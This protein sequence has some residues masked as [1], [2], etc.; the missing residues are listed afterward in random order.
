MKKSPLISAALIGALA[1]ILA[2]AASALPPVKG[3]ELKT[4][5]WRFAFR[6]P[7][8]TDDVPVVLVTIDDQS[9]E[10]LP[11][12][13]PWPRDYYA[14]VVRNLKKAGARVVALDLIFDIPDPYGAARDSALARA[15][16]EAGNVVL[17]AKL[18]RRTLL[19]KIQSQSYLVQPM[20]LFLQAD[21]SMGLVAIQADPDGIYRR[22]IVAEAY[23]N[24]WI[25][26]LALEILRRYKHIPR[27]VPILPEKK[28][29]VL[30]N[31]EIPLYQANTILI[32]FAGPAGSFTQYSFDNI[33]D[34]AEFRLKG[35]YDLDTFEDLLS[36]GVFKDKIVLV[37][38]VA[39]ELKDNFPTPFLEFKDSQGEVQKA[40]M[41][42]VE[43]HANAIRTIMTG[44]YYHRPARWLLWLAV[45]ALILLVELLSLRLPTL[46]ATATTVGLI[47]LVGAG[48]FWSF[49]S[50]RLVWEMVFPVL[51][52]ALAFVGIN[53]YQYVRTQKEKQMIIGAFA[54]YVPEKVV[55][56]LLA[57]PEKLV[58][59]GEERF[60]TVM[61]TDVANFTSISERLSPRELVNLINEYLTEMTEIVFKYDG[62][63]D[64]Y[65][66][67]AI[68][69]EF[70]APVYFED[71]ARKA[72]L[73]ALEM[74]ERLIEL[75]QRWTKL[76]LPPLTCRA[77]INSGT[78]IVGNMGSRRVFDY[79]V[80]GDEV[81][82]A[83]RL[84]GANKIFR[85]RI[86]ISESTRKL[87][88]DDFYTR[89]LD[90]IRVKGKQKPVQVFELMA[91]KN[92]RFDRIMLNLLPVYENGIRYYRNREW[93]KAAACFRYCLKLRPHDG[94]SQLYLRRVVEYAKNPP[95]EDWDG[96]FVMKTK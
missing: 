38:A 29:I 40:E 77:G 76:K 81:N 65:E 17:A 24:R 44:R 87:I 32:N 69:A 9:F 27:T 57:H 41:P 73:A 49:L 61:F 74:Q 25:P 83:S 35:D 72:C 94:P 37:G 48:E 36:E 45:A 75:R 52:M 91:V 8:P 47:L 15:I 62:I 21:S 59:G 55:N 42:G 82:L 16:A 90:L 28:S 43:I 96:V 12:R 80:L 68:M 4:V 79:T 56:D 33:I 14:R 60:M 7:E 67:D 54:R 1:F 10:S 86:M 20:P 51:G 58:L 92:E 71:H 95:P 23:Q 39:S 84:E 3:L 34:D 46:W 53:L 88:E 66:G 31:L 5:D 63:I 89:T 50:A 18:E 11:D 22:Y 70:G 19:G 6:G 2:L 78:M 85:T 93:K 30:G 13:W 64:K 26:S